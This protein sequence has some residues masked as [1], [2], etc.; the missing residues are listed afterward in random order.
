M[1]KTVKTLSWLFI[2]KDRFQFDSLPKGSLSIRKIAIIE[3]LMKEFPRYTFP[4]LN[5]IGRKTYV[6]VQ[7]KNTAGR[8]FVC[9]AGGIFMYSY[10]GKNQGWGLSIPQG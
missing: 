4:H 2:K 8:T 7:E 5:R 6:F 1:K 10:V 3:I 9:A